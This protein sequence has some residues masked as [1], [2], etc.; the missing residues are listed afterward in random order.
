MKTAT[1]DACEEQRRRE[2]Q[3]R[4]DY[5]AGLLYEF[6]ALLGDASEAEARAHETIDLFFVFMKN[7]DW[8]AEAKNIPAYMLEQTRLVSEGAL[9]AGRAPSEIEP[10][11]CEVDKADGMLH[12]IVDAMIQPVRERLASIGS[13]AAR[14]SPTAAAR[15]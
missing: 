15:G 5:Y 10:S 13:F 11:P 3:I 12:K 9:A 6:W 7:Q 8:E 4:N 14:T 1:I 2:E